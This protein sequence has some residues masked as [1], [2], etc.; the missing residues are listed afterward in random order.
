VVVVNNILPNVTY[1]VTVT[2]SRPY[3]NPA[4]KLIKVSTFTDT[5]LE[6]PL[7][8]KEFTLYLS[9]V[10]SVSGDLIAPYS[11]LVDN[12]TVIPSTTS[13]YAEVRVLY[14]THVLRV[15][16]APGYENVYESFET[17]LAISSN[18]SVDVTLF[19]TSDILSP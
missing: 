11:V 15:G 4:E 8:Y 10:D 19:A 17:T 6:I 3:V 9:V 12:K 16:P 14:G 18:Q 2:H 7:T 1:E 13:R 5:Y